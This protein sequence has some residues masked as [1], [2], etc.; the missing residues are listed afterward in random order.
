M[1]IRIFSD[2]ARCV[3]CR[4]L[5]TS[6]TKIAVPNPEY[7]SHRRSHDHTCYCNDHILHYAALSENQ[8]GENDLQV[9]TEG[10]CT[11]CETL[12]EE[13]GPDAVERRR[14]ADTPMPAELMHDLE[15]S[16]VE[17]RDTFFPTDVFVLVTE[18]STLPGTDAGGESLRRFFTDSIHHQ[19]EFWMQ[20]RV[21]RQ[22]RG[23]VTDDETML[24]E[25]ELTF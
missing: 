14:T 12:L 11:L 25:A 20:E 21:R 16:M 22:V 24:L 18:S 4:H 15:M 3:G 23:W 1:C 19:D 10:M 2:F 8:H 7:E 5:Y 6:A 9:Q 17:R 13:E